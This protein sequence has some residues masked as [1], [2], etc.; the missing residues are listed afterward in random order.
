[1]PT[2]RPRSADA[3]L[4]PVINEHEEIAEDADDQ[5][6]WNE[7]GKEDADMSEAAGDACAEYA[8]EAYEEF[9]EEVRIRWL[10]PPREPSSLSLSLQPWPF[11][12]SPP[13]TLPLPQ[14]AQ[15]HAGESCQREVLQPSLM[16]AT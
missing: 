7:D 15:M 9:S 14:Q 10:L 12:P 16:A 3:Q 6:D 5:E 8:G 13:P 2:P 4:L 11:P 1:M